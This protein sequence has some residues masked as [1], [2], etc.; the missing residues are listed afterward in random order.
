MLLLLLLPISSIAHLWILSSQILD[1]FIFFRKEVSK[2]VR[3]QRTARSVKEVS[4]VVDERVK[5]TWV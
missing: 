2:N 5:E 1:F 3:H 4:G